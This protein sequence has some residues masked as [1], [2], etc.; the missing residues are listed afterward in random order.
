[1]RRQTIPARGWGRS[2][3]G[4]GALMRAGAS[5]P[6]DMRL[7]RVLERVHQCLPG[8]LD[9]VLRDTDRPPLALAVGGVEE[10]PGHGARAVV[11]VE[12]PDLVVGE[13]DVGE[14]G[15]AVADRVPE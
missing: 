13:L 6:L 10:D 5:A 7:E 14:M 12:D 8:G 11:L 1:M 3:R 4:R 9:D 2:P 15:V